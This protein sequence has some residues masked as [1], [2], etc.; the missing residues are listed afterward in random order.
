MRCC[1]IGSNAA[2]PPENPLPSRLAAAR[3]AP[4]AVGGAG[5]RDIR[6]VFR[7]HPHRAA[8]CRRHLAA[9]AE[10]KSDER[11]H[12]F[13]CINE[14]CAG[15]EPITGLSYAILRFTFITGALSSLF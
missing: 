4:A 8:P 6:H 10:A 5:G 1:S 14:G 2:P 9:G 7:G 13:G 15:K 3:P 11:R 12:Q